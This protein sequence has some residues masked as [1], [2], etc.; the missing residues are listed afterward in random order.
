M[1]NL[2]V[3]LCN[4]PALGYSREIFTHESRPDGEERNKQF[5]KVVSIK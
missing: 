5:P 3:L 1:E 2:I 4:Y